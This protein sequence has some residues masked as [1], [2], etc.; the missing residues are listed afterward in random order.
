MPVRTVQ[1]LKLY[2]P[3]HSGKIESTA[4]CLQRWNLE[5]LTRN[6]DVQQQWN[7]LLGQPVL[8]HVMLTIMLSGRFCSSQYHAVTEVCRP[9]VRQTDGQHNC[10]LT[11]VPDH[12]SNLQVISQNTFSVSLKSSRFMTC[13]GRHTSV[14]TFS[15]TVHC[16]RRSAKHC[17]CYKRDICFRVCI[18]DWQHLALFIAYSSF[19]GSYKKTRKQLKAEIPLYMLSMTRIK[20]DRSWHHS[21]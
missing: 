8:T 10:T 15:M 9:K 17:Q 2:K 13:R 7:P 4:Y 19:A 14:L 1:S 12:G 21:F 11:S 5:I 6:H 3:L 18:S 20:R 16:D